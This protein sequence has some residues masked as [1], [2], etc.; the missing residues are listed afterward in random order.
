MF[1]FG[2]YPNHSTFC[3]S[4]FSFDFYQLVEIFFECDL[5]YLKFLFFALDHRIMNLI[6]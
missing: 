2:L 5:Y 1:F 6:P 3:S 4:A